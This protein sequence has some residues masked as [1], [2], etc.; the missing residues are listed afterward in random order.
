MRRVRG[1]G[2]GGMIFT[3]ADFVDLGARAA[4][5]QAL[6][7]LVKAGTLRRVGRG[8]YDWPRQ[9]KLLG[10]DAPAAA[11]D[12]AAAAARRVGVTTAP[13]NLAAANALGL[14]TAVLS[15]P[16]YMASRKLGD[17]TVGTLR[18]KFRPSGAKLAPLLNTDAAVIV[19]ALAWA[20]D[21]GFDLNEAAAKIARTASDA[22]TSALAANLRRLPVW[23]LGP[24]REIL[25]NRGT[26]SA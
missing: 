1:H 10:G 2:R 25:R 7:R 12:V 22:A 3:P 23:A 26:L 8:L 9:S 16:A 19:Q 14:T 6:S 13:D 15:R 11:D 24:A 5:D 18:V 20:R 21:S 4:V 17:R